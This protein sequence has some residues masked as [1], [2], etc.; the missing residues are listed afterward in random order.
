[1][2]LDHQKTMGRKILD[3]MEF[4]GA[5]R[6]RVDVGRTQ[7][8]Q[9]RLCPITGITVMQKQARTNRSLALSEIN[10]RSHLSE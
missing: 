8:L 2:I 1:M 4:L 10:E 6:P 7:C 3:Q 5:N 9:P